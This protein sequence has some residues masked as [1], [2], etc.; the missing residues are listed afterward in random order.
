M[1]TA[2]VRNLTMENV[3]HTLPEINFFLVAKNAQ[4]CGVF[5]LSTGNDT[6]FSNNN[7]NKEEL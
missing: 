2:N 5:L 3:N 4:F 1:P 7:K 6:N